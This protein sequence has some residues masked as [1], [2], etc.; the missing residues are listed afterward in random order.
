MVA[1]F[2]VFLCVF[3]HMTYYLCSSAYVPLH[4][5]LLDLLWASGLKPALLQSASI[6]QE[7]GCRNAPGGLLLL[8]VPCKLQ[9]EL[10]VA[11]PSPAASIQ[12]QIYPASSEGD[13]SIICTRWTGESR[14]GCQSL[15]RAQHPVDAPK[16]E[17]GYQQSVVTDHLHPVQLSKRVPGPPKHPVLLALPF[18]PAVWLVIC[19]L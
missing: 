15:K 16:G 1:I 5:L 10:S 14:L 13:S 2:C 19:S 6:L 4:T 9:R 17:L 3:Q 12:V 8:Q 18:L 11:E 7:D